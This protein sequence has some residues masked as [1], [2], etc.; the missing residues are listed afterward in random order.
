MLPLF[1]YLSIGL[2]VKVCSPEMDATTL[3]V[4]YLANSTNN[5]IWNSA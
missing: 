1:T 2:I 5:D 4:E 3:K